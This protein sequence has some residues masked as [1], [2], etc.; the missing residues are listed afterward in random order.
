MQL[1]DAVVRSP[2]WKWDAGMMHNTGNVSETRRKVLDWAYESEDIRSI[3][4][5]DLMLYD[6]A[7][8]IFKRQTGEILGTVWV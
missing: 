4:A 6:I 2:V 3:I 8:D 1:F 7:K 5:A